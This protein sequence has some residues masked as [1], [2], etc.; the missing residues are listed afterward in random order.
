MA[1]PPLRVAARSG[2]RVEN[3]SA[4]GI[5]LVKESDVTGGAKGL[6]LVSVQGP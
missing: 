5:R 3:H 6:E 4:R 2:N 1:A